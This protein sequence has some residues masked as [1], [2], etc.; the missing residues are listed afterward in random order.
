MWEGFEGVGGREGGKVGGEQMANVDDADENEPFTL[1]DGNANL[2]NSYETQ[3]IGV[4]KQ[5]TKIST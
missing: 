4:F 5:M 3:Y 1:A 2:S